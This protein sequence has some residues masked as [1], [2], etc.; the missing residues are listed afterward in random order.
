MSSGIMETAAQS[1]MEE[2]SLDKFRKELTDLINKHSSENIGDTPDFILA[3]TICDFIS[4]QGRHTKRLL[5]WHG[6]DSICH[7][8]NDSKNV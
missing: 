5:D 3:D 1:Q 7:P 6:C 2:S 4:T 8:K